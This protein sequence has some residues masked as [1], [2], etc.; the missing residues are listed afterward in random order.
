MAYRLIYELSN[1]EF[2]GM[3]PDQVVIKLGK[4]DHAN[5][6]YKNGKYVISSLHYSCYRPAK[7]TL[8]EFEKGGKSLKILYGISQATLYFKESQ[9]F[10][11]SSGIRPGF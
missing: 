3:T 5:I 1:S 10:Y 8:D 2:K 11:V 4:A 6:V 7:D 9:C